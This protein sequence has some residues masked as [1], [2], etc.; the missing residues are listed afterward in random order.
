MIRCETFNGDR[1]DTWFPISAGGKWYKMFDIIVYSISNKAVDWKAQ[2]K[3]VSTSLNLVNFVT[4]SVR[5]DQTNRYLAIHRSK[6]FGTLAHDF[7]GNRSAYEAMFEIVISDYK[8]LEASSQ[9]F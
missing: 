2:Q 6:A 8:T 4:Y 7:K 5:D 1:S 9:I 3:G